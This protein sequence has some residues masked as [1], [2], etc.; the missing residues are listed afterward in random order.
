LIKNIYI[1]ILLLSIVGRWEYIDHDHIIA[2]NV[3]KFK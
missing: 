1:Y 2:V 3:K